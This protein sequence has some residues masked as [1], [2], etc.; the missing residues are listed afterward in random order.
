MR[1]I[2]IA[3]ACCW[4]IAN[5]GSFDT[6]D[7]NP[8]L[9]GFDQPH[10]YSARLPST[11]TTELDV[12]LNW[13]NTSLIQQSSTEA[14]T[15][16]AESREWRV[17][18]EHS[19]TDS[20]AVRIELPYRTLNGGSLD[21]FIERWHSFFGLPNGKRALMPRNTYLI[22]YQRN[23]NSLVNSASGESGLG[24]A[25]LA[26]GYQLYATPTSATSAWW[27][28]KFPTGAGDRLTGRGAFD[29][30]LSVA[31][32][33]ALS[34]RWTTFAQVDGIYLGSGDFLSAQQRRFLWSGLFGFDYRYSSALTFTVQFAGHTAA[35]TDSSLDLLGNAW[36]ATFGGEFHFNKDWRVQLGV[37]EDIKVDASPDV[38]FIISIKKSL[39]S[40]H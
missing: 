2:G 12:S 33:H 10:P 31:H 11:R 36:I 22:G 21:S 29:S 6:V 24:D 8:L 23:G 7:Q 3:T 32:E 25:V 40:S 19:L 15:V 4:T 5:A 39:A 18:V 27:N 1:T 35:F 38:T 34:G 16:D 17:S 30:A 20:W 26:V 9:S 37:T 13:S 14:L 28:L